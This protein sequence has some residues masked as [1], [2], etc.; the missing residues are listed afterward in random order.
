MPVLAT[1]LRPKPRPSTRLRPARRQRKERNL[2][3][4]LKVFTLKQALPA[5]VVP[6]VAP[7]AT[8][9]RAEQSLSDTAPNGSVSLGNASQ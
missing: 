6:E 4:K 3:R 8:G 7:E 9:K 5:K 2:R 1:A